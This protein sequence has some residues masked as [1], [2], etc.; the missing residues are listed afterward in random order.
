[1]NSTGDR[2][3]QP[4]LYSSRCCSYE[5]ALAETQEFPVCGTC[6]RST[7]WMAVTPGTASSEDARRRIA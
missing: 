3:Q 5:N 1:M 6:G 4:G 2:V 7:E